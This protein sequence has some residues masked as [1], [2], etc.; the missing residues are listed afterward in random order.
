M[1]KP[2]EN[3]NRRNELIRAIEEA[4]NSRVITYVTSNR[5]NVQSDIESADV[6]HFRE[7]LE[8]ICAKCKSLDLFLFSYGG[9]LEAAW[10]LVNLF[11]EYNIDFSVLVPFH[12]RSAATLITLGA[13]E[14]VMGKMASLGPIDPTIRITGGELDGM[15]ISATDMDSFEDF[16]REEYQVTKP[17]DKMKGFELL[18]QSVSPILIGQAYR[19]Y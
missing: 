5:P 11:R 16:L 6:V 13:R 14:T 9:E 4:R 3:K 8:E 2:P 12:A 7:H 1:K 15:E 18:A 17:Q 10:E 19:N